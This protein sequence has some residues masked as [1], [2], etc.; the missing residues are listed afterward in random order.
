MSSKGI[1]NASLG[2]CLKSL[3]IPAVCD[4]HDTVWANSAADRFRWAEAHQMLFEF[5]GIVCLS[6]RSPLLCCLLVH[7]IFQDRCSIPQQHAL[8]SSQD[9]RPCLSCQASCVCS[10]SDYI[11]LS[12]H[13]YLRR[14]GSC[15]GGEWH[16]GSVTMKPRRVRH[17]PWSAGA[18]SSAVSAQPP[19]ARSD[20][21]LAPATGASGRPPWRRAIAM[22]FLGVSG[23]PR[24]GLVLPR[25]A[26]ASPGE[27]RGV[28]WEERGSRGVR[29]EEDGGVRTHGEPGCVLRSGA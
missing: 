24:H 19:S 23:E 13:R 7:G 14:G 26:T 17:I 15:E 1:S 21:S 16:A 5:V 9:A 6:P 8:R 22:A 18:C 27:R 10:W 11:A 20:P 12:T 4:E 25:A 2:P 29:W 28:V 3:D